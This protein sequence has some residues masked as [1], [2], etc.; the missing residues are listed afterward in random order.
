V[1]LTD[2]IGLLE[3]IV[4]LAFDED[5]EWIVVDLKTD[6]IEGNHA[7]TSPAP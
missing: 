3:G 6:N 4:D 2:D 1:T 7:N 5:G